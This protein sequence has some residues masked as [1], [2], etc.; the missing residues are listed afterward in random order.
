MNLH[1]YSDESGVLD[2]KHNKYYTFGGLIFTSG[3]ERDWISRK[4][5]A[6]EENIRLSEKIEPEAE[7]KACNIDP[8]SRNKLYRSIADVEKFGAVISQEKLTNDLLF[9]NKKSKQRYLDWAYKMAVRRK[10]EQMIARGLIEPRSIDMITF[11]VDEHS[12]ATNGLYELEASLEKE[13]KIGTWNYDY[14]TFHE[15]LFPNINILKVKYCN[16]AKI[17][18]VRSADIIANRLFYYAN[19]QNG[20]IPLEDKMHVFYHP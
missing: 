9:E 2:K 15:P 11:M 16:S 8:K 6:A 3:E 13:F 4:Y 1:I 12:T 19:I 10:L 14:M 5:L 18:L 20:R 17:T 7:V